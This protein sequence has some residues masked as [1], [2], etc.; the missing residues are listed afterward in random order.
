MNTHSTAVARF[1]LAL[2]L[3]TLGQEYSQEAAAN[4]LEALSYERD[5]ANDRIRDLE[6]TCLPSVQ[7]AERNGFAKGFRAGVTR[8]AQMEV[9]PTTAD[10]IT[11]LQPNF[12]LAAETM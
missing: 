5:L 7:A 1:C 12:A 6:T 4:L 8:A 9:N 10:A 11:Q 3:G 2:K